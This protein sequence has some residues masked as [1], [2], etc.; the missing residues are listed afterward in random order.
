MKTLELPGTRNSLDAILEFVRAAAQA[1]GLARGAAYHLELAVDELATNIIV[2]GYE[3]AG[4]PGALNLTARWDDTGL[5]VEIVDTAAPYDP[6]ERAEP[7]SLEAALDD[8]PIGGLGVFLALRA[9]D[10][11][12]YVSANGRNRSILVMKRRPAGSAGA[13]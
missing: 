1:A 7:A 2:H 3:E 10:H 13:P 9:V 8:R 5:T 4:H 6:R 12:D 11:F